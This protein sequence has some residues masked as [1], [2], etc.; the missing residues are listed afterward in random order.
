[1]RYT[2]KMG[3]AAN[4]YHAQ[5]KNAHPL[6]AQW[7]WECLWTAMLA[8]APEEHVEP[9]VTVRY[10]LSPAQVEGKVREQLVKMGWTPPRDP[11][12]PKLRMTDE[13]I[14]NEWHEA[15]GYFV[16][17]PGHSTACFMPFAEYLN[18][19]RDLDAKTVALAECVGRLKLRIVFI[20][21]PGES[22]FNV[23]SDKYD[24]WVPDWR[25]ELAL[26]EHALH[27]TPVDQPEKP[28]DTTK[29]IDLKRAAHRGYRNLPTPLGAGDTH[30][31]GP[32]TQDY[33]AGYNKAL[34][35]AAEAMESNLGRPAA[36]EFSAWVAV[37]NGVEDLSAPRP[38]VAAETAT[39]RDGVKHP[40]QPLCED[41]H[42]VLRFKANAIVR[43]LL[44][45]GG[46]GMNALAVEDFTREDREQFAQ[47][48]G[49]SHTGAGT[50]SYMSD[51]AWFAAQDE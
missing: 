20:G 43:Y 33:V 18:F 19:R 45:N 13:Q 30:P 51:A 37:A 22:Y 46:I 25:Y 16:K 34:G 48:I 6:P 10:D 14:Q 35:R 31:E 17:K 36:R 28:T 21:W 42:G 3:E 15:K 5:L 1:M 8:A 32:H 40:V 2:A 12:D 11:A 4:A 9:T 44:D 49:Y 38:A 39:P 47:L 23:G 41:K 29:S 7:R 27:G 24:W 50:L 26:I